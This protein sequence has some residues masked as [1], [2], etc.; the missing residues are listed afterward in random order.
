VAWALNLYTMRTDGSAA[1]QYL[2]VVGITALT[3]ALYFVAYSGH[4]DPV[5]GILTP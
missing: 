5:P 1:V 2:K 4:A 3:F